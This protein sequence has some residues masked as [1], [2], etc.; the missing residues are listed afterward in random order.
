MP[1]STPL[2]A[3]P[4]PPPPR[5]PAPAV[6]LPL[7]ES[8]LARTEIILRKQIASISAIHTETN[9]VREGGDKHT[10]QFNGIVLDEVEGNAIAAALGNKKAA[11]LQN[12]GLLVASSSIEATVKFYIALE[13]ACQAQLMADAAAAAHGGTTVLIDHEQAADT[14]RI[15]GSQRAG[16]YGGTSEFVLLERKEGVAFNLNLTQNGSA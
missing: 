3:P 4:P 8:L 5:C 6:V 13:R 9:H 14:A 10:K 15:L 11:I 12:H 1:A 16:W 7:L 2:S